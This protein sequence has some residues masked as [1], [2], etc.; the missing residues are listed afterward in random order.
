MRVFSLALRLICSWLLLSAA[1]LSAAQ[2]HDGRD[3]ATRA[4][5][6]A[7]AAVR[8]Q[9]RLIVLTARKKLRA[10]DF[11]G[12]QLDC[13]RAI[14]L[15]ESVRSHGNSAHELLAESYFAQ[16]KMQEALKEAYIPEAGVGSRLAMTRALILTKLG[17]YDDAYAL[18]I[19]ETG[20]IDKPE[21]FR[22][23]YT[24][25][26]LPL[27]RGNGADYLLA[28]AYII[29]ATNN[30]LADEW[31]ADFEKAIKLSARCASVEL[32]YGRW[33]YVNQ[34][35]GEAVSHIEKALANGRDKRTVERAKTLLQQAKNAVARQKSG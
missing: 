20:T 5:A 34:F 9:A 3:E 28:T 19:A 2:H 10:G 17:R 29:R 4:A 8:R 31:R 26:E 14:T 35:P 23:S 13:D 16:G 6:N 24:A 25:W 1:A 12:V 18:V 15:E 7:D 32:V 27:D 11:E 22:Q 33:L 21:G 30:E